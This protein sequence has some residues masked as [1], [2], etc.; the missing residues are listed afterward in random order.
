MTPLKW[1]V[2]EAKK[3]KKQYPHRFKKW[4]D[5]VAQASAIYASKH[6]GKSPVGKKHKVSGVKKKAAKKKA[7]K[8]GYSKL[9]LSN[10]R[11]LTKAIK[12]EPKTL[13]PYTDK[14]KLVI[15][16][17]KHYDKL[18]KEIH[19]VSGTKKKAVKKSAARMLHKDTKSHNVNIRVM[20]GIDK[21]TDLHNSLKR[22]EGAIKTI[23]YITN[24][25]KTIPA[26][27]KSLKNHWKRELKEN[28]RYLITL[29]KHISSIKKHI[30]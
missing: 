2:N 26:K 24:H 18:N 25:I 29:N 27:E 4:T 28:K 13:F 17:K 12:N 21:M 19:K 10:D 23:N 22:K 14:Q 1:I 6:K 15:A 30:K 9:R 20:S 11:Q 5:Y 8:V 3:L 16:A 7:G